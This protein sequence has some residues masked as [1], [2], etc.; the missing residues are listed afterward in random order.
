[1]LSIDVRTFFSFWWRANSALDFYADRMHQVQKYPW[2]Y[3]PDTLYPGR[4]C[5]KLRNGLISWFSYAGDY[6]PDTKIRFTTKYNRP[7]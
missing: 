3:K 4:Y 7:D 2:C 1:M 5:E 6:S